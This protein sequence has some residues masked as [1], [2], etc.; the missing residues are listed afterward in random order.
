MTTPRFATDRLLLR[1]IRADDVETIFRC[2][3]RDETVSR[4]M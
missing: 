3:M 1:E 4:Y 2:W